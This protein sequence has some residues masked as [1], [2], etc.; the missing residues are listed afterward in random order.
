MTMAHHA[1]VTTTTQHL[2]GSLSGHHHH[3][4]ADPRSATFV[5]RSHLAYMIPATTDLDLEEAFG[6]IENGE[7]F[8]DAVQQRQSLFFGMKL[9][10]P[11][12]PSPSP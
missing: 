12:P 5:E 3:T 7:S 1:A 4:T 9:T 6:N 11:F 8:L 10:P 2:A